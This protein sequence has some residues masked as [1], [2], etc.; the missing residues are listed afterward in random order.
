[1]FMMYMEDFC[2]VLGKIKEIK[3]VTFV[4]RTTKNKIKIII[5]YI[6]IEKG[7]ENILAVNTD[8]KV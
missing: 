1:M 5:N 4:N 3:Y 2:K 6:E 8:E 7:F